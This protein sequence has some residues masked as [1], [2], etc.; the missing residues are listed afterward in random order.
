MFLYLETHLQ[1]KQMWLLLKEYTK[2]S[3]VEKWHGLWIWYRKDWINMHVC[4]VLLN[5]TDNYKQS[6]KFHGK[7]NT[8]PILSQAEK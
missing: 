5:V 1:Q 4:K 3:P 7:K 2:N 8:T 6:V